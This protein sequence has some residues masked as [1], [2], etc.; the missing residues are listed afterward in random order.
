M[1]CY[2][3]SGVWQYHH[4]LLI[5]SKQY[6]LRFEHLSD[7]AFGVLRFAG[8]PSLSFSCPSLQICIALHDI[9]KDICLFCLV[10][11]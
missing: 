5:L 4:S 9:V 1:A 2:I 8:V 11:Q 6:H 10:C 7:I 3:L